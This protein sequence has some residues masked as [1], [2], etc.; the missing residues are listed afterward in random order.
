M[1]QCK[2]LLMGNPDSGPL[3][4]ALRDVVRSTLWSV[5]SSC[6]VLLPAFSFN[7]CYSP[8]NL[9]TCLH[10]SVHFSEDATDT[11]VPGV[12]Q[13]SKWYI[14]ILRPDPSLPDCKEEPIP[15]GMWSIISPWH[16]RVGQRLKLSTGGEHWN[17]IPDKKFIDS[18]AF[19]WNTGLN[20]PERIRGGGTNSLLA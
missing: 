9:D 15:A 17:I 5:N 4:W 3:C 7:R 16:N 11:V 1:A 18:G 8:V 12:S 20:S 10:L 14:G 2:T 19:F 6:S 13:K